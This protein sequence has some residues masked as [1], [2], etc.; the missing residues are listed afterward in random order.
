MSRVYENSPIV[1]ALCEF[2]FE[3]SQRWDWAVPG[4]FYNEVKQEFPIRRQFN[5]FPIDVRAESQQGLVQNVVSNVERMQ[6]VRQ[7]ERALVQVGPDLMSVHHLKP[8][9]NWKTFKQMIGQS[10]DV[11]K[12]VADP[13][14]ITRV[15]LRYINRLEMPADQMIKIER[16]LLAVPT[17]PYNVPQDFTS[18]WQRVE[19]PFVRANG[20]LIIQSGSLLEEGQANVTFLLDLDFVTLQADLVAL[21]GTLEW[22][23]RAHDEIEATFEACLTDETRRLIGEVGRGG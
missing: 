20:L 15:G 7:D 19:I 8:Y 11:Y 12:R 17:V 6:F 3:P 14:S 21:D 4:L 2:R 16:F 1:E 9:S 5:P 22:V 13:K 18:W 23:D 10:L